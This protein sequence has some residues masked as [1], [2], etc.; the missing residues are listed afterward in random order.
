MKESSLKN[1][2]VLGFI[3]CLL[4]GIVVGAY[5]EHIYIVRSGWSAVDEHGHWDHAKIPARLIE[6]TTTAGVFSEIQIKRPFSPTY[7][8][9]HVFSRGPDAESQW[10]SVAYRALQ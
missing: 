10:P 3:I 7:D 2:I 6:R 5:G 8:T 4:V 1:N 9:V